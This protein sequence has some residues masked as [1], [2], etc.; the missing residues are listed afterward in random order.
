[1]R[2]RCGRSDGGEADDGQGDERYVCDRLHG[3]YEW[4]HRKS[5]IHCDSLPRK[6]AAGARQAGRK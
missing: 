3:G 5:S 4:P 6:F 2:A 1:L